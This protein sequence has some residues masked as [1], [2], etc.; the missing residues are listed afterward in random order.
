ML[1]QAPFPVP[2]HFQEAL[3]ENVGQMAYLPVTG[4]YHPVRLLVWSLTFTFCKVQYT[5][6][7]HT[8][9]IY[10]IHV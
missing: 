9:I 4:M 10:N 1:F 5:C 3:R 8:Y 2:E 7:G 6:I